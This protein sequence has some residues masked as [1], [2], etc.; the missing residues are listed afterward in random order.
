MFQI[1]VQGR[2]EGEV[3]T[4]AELL[5]AAAMAEGM[6]AVASAASRAESPVSICTIDGAAATAAAEEPRAVADALIVQDPSELRHMDV[7]AWLHPEAY[8]LVNSTC[9][10]GDLG[11]SERIERFCRDRALIVP[12]ARLDLGL[13]E[14]LVRSASMVGGFAALSRV[15]SL[16]SVVS[17]IRDRIPESLAWACEEAA[18]AAYEFVRAAKEALAA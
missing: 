4:T 12:A 6:R 17:A 8:V 15:V 11:I 5:A 16:G 3:L 7:F 2:N 1:R 9:G 14:G 18:V 13:H 10:F